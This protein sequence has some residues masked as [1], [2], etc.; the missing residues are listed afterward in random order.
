IAQLLV[1]PGGRLAF[2][3]GDGTS[4][5]RAKGRAGTATY[6]SKVLDAQAPAQFGSLA[7]RSSGNVTMETRS[8]NTEEPG[9]GWSAWQKL[10]DAHPAGGGGQRAKVAS[11]P[12]RYLQF[13]AKLAS[14]DA[15]LRQTA[16]YYL[17][18]NRP[19]RILDI[20]VTGPE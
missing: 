1:E 18:Q 6:T 14:D 12:G 9:P 17:A 15:V 4:L 2:V 13:R 10:R 11:P 5:Y 20:S 16:I 8:G 19:T 3:T 7:W